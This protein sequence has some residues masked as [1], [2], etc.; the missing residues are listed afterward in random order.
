VNG[1]GDFEAVLCRKAQ[2][3]LQFC[4]MGHTISVRLTKEIAAWLEETAAKTGISQGKIIR[5]QL[6]RAMK[7]GAP[8]TFLRLAGTIRGPK[9]LSSRKGFSRS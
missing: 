1:L 4:Q 6:E 2:A 7:G 5:D 9:D 8:R 3:V